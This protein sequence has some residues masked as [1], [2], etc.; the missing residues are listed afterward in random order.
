[1]I[2]SEK[3]K[4]VQVQGGNENM[5]R[6]W[7][8]FWRE[9]FWGLSLTLMGVL[10]LALSGVL[11]L[12]Q[13]G[14]PNFTLADGQ[15]LTG[16]EFE[17]LERQNRAYERIAETVTPAIVNIR[18]TQVIKVQQSPFFMDPF[19]R[20]F[21]GDNFGQFGIPREQRQHA[22]GSGV[23]VSADGYIVT[24]NHVIAK[25]TDVEVMLSDKRTF[26]AKV[27]GAD[28]RTDVAVIKIDA[29]DL[30]T[31]PWGDSN[32]LRP[33]DIV[34]AFGNPFGLN[35]AVTRG[36]VNAVGRSGLGIETYEDFIQTD[37]AIN[38]GNSGGALVNVR[39]QVIGI[40]TAILSASQGPDGQGGFNGIGFAIPANVV[41]HVMES[42]IKT[43]KV[44]R[45]YLGISIGDLN[46]ALARQFKVPDVSGVLV[47]QV[48][49]GSAAEKG[50]M[51]QGDVIRTLNGQNVDS[52][53]R[54]RAMVAGINPGT[55]VT[56]GILR[57][58]K[59]ET[60]KIT[61]AEQPA[62]MAGPG[63]AEKGPSEG[64]L[65]GISVQ[66]LTP[67]LRQQLGLAPN[68]HGVVISDLDPDSPAA[69]SGL[70]QG[71]VIES[72]NRQPVSSVADFNRLAVGAT[73]EV[74]LRVNRQGNSAYVVIS[75]S[76][77]DN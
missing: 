75:P 30:P 33:G 70:Q 39:G 4:K 46:P 21:F 42:L 62:S 1:M 7:K 63:G 55:E 45:G 52:A 34:M 50:G 14:Y 59:P 11:Y 53:D 67:S 72:I 9:N 16:P 35:F 54:L 24:N 66:D 18:T 36:S 47:N 40:N 48:E 41:K 65:R 43:G 61:L 31:V 49:P 51:K 37:A 2:A 13:R 8:N 22:L 27:I 17:A 10:L 25:A 28:P 5:Q 19:F 26:K 64:T 56:L 69:Q 20:Q 68:T 77:D 60:I 3:V 6:T 38:P 15:A 23:I 74:L 57:D 29:K 12:G 71:D 76:G 73:G 58:G 44:T 32:T